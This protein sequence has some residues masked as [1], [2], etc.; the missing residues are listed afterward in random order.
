MWKISAEVYSECAYWDSVTLETKSYW[1]RTGSVLWSFDERTG[2]LNYESSPVTPPA[3]K[4]PEDTSYER[5]LEIIKE[6]QG[7]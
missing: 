3:P 2:S 6:L 1:V 7:K 4:T 5:L